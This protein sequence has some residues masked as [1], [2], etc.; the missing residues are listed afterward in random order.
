M[1]IQTVNQTG[2][3]IAAPVR[4]FS[5]PEADEE[6]LDTNYRGW[7]TIR[8]AATPWLILT[9]FPILEGYNYREVQAA[10]LIPSGYPN[11]PLDMVYFLPALSRTSGRPITGLASQP[12]SGQ[13]WQ[14]WSRHYAWRPGTDDLVTHIERIKTWL[15]AQLAR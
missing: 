12:I 9:R 2:A 3:A 4:H 11:A 7:Q 13:L 15:E 5:L 14:R 8:D 10:I 1:V 6:F